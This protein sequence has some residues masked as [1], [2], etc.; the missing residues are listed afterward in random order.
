M[1]REPLPLVN[2]TI[3]PGPYRHRRTGRI[4]TVLGGDCC[5]STGMYRPEWRI[6]L[7]YASGRTGERPAY[8]VRRDYE[9]LAPDEP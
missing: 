8:A 7:R 9:P 2:D 1:S 6:R 3:P 5:D 4:D